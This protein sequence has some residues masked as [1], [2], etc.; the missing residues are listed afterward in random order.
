MFREPATRRVFER[1]CETPEVHATAH[2]TPQFSLGTMSRPYGVGDPPEPWPGHN[3]CIAYWTQG[4]E[5]GYGVLYCRYRVDAGPAGRVARPAAHWLDIWEEGLFR[6]AQSGT[7]AIVGYGLMPRGQRPAT[8]LR[9]DIRIL[10]A[11][12]RVLVGEGLDFD[13]VAASEP[14]PIVVETGDFLIGIVP[15]DPS[16]LGHIEPVYTWRDGQ[17]VV[18]SIINYEGPP[19][20][21]W[22]YRSLSGPF[23]KGNVRNGFC[24]RIAERSEFASAE[25][26]RDEL[27]AN[28]PTD[29]MDG[30]LRRI[31]WGAGDDGLTLEYDL[32]TMW[33]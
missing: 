18:V 14:S 19:K 2:V 8:G 5:P 1:V 6:C 22:E 31:T 15:L 30:S 3:S 13:E 20:Q 9:L 12:S 21:F 32:R 16:R 4:A 23:F 25:E 17:E 27:A 28:P 29:D 10:A 26:F 7:R 24:L 33:P 11:E